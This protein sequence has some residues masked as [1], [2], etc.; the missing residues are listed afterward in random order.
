MNRP[1]AA[2]A[3]TA[4]AAGLAPSA[5]D[6]G[7]SARPVRVRFDVRMLDDGGTTMRQTG[8]F[9]GAPFGRGRVDI[10]SE[11]GQGKGAKVTFLL[12]TPAGKL[13]GTG[14]VKLT[15]SGTN[16]RYSGTAA[17]VAGTRRYAKAR[18]RSLRLDG[19][20]DMTGDHFSVRLTGRVAGV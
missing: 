20:G 19:G 8:T 16:V 11:V 5:A 4:L 14:E 17:I 6:A 15:F 13:R 2:L 9:S 7:A 3:L 12:T 18:S 10:R 1:L